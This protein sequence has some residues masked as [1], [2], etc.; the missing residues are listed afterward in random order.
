M[1]DDFD[2]LESFIARLEQ[3]IARTR[4]AHCKPITD[5][6]HIAA[7]HD[8]IREQIEAGGASWGFSVGWLDLKH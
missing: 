1:V 7:L 5:S 6:A 3:E 4:P 2:F 8:R